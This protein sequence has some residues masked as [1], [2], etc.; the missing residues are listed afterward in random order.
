[1]PWRQPPLESDE[2]GIPAV[3]AP[4]GLAADDAVA[5]VDEAVT[6]ATALVGRYKGPFCPQPASNP[7]ASS[8]AAEMT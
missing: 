7:K 8:S 3:A 5:G 4:A 1:M 6:G 2:A